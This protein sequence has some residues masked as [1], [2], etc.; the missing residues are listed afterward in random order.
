MEAVLALLSML[1]LWLFLLALAVALDEIRQSLESASRSLAKIAMGVRAI[2]NETGALP[3]EVPI[4]AAAL[5]RIAD[6]GEAIAGVL[7]SVDGRLAAI[8]PAEG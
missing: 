3:V 8:A 1:L 4:T 2:E 6:G 5:T 7:G